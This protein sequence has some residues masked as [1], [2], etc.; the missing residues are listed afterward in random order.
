MF[1]SGP[2]HKRDQ[3]TRLLTEL[4]QLQWLFIGDDGQLDPSL[5]A[6]AA[7]GAEPGRVR[8]IGIRQLSAA[9]QVRTHG[10]PDP[11]AAE[12]L[13]PSG[14]GR[15]GVAAVVR[16]PDGF[17]LLRALR[18]AGILPAGTDDP[19]ARRSRL[20]RFTGSLPRGARR[21]VAVPTE[22]PTG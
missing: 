16:A 22:G 2:Q 13:P 8:G 12:P 7:A 11:R 3:L 9:Q 20:R 19:G 15:S 18:S 4:P 5:Y 17:G 21:P 1:R 14:P 10:S 6:D